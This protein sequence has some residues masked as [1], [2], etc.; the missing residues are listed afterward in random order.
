[1]S[2][3]ILECILIQA[4]KEVVFREDLYNPP[5]DLNQIDMVHFLESE[6]L[7]HGES[8]PATA[9]KDII[10]SLGRTHRDCYHR[11]VVTMFQGR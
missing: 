10:E 1:M 2:T 11:F 3:L 9:N 5:V 6:N 7:P 4:S 8:I